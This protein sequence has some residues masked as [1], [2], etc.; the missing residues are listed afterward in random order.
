MEVSRR[1]FA[2]FDTG[3][4]DERMQS[5]KWQLLQRVPWW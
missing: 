3:A 4:I 2:S 1:H 5:N